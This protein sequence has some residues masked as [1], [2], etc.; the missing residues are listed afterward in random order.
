MKNDCNVSIGEQ[1]AAAIQVVGSASSLARQ[2]GVTPQA[3]CFWRDG[4]RRFP[5]ALGARI[6]AITSG[7]VTRKDMFPRDW[8][9][10]WP[11]LAD[12]EE[13][14]APAP[15]QQAQAA[16]NHDVQGVVHG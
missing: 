11:E 16:I 1:I 12:S 3:V 14:Q 7:R 5:E 6:E 10:I 4:K 9:S 13:K 2:L 15:T 8:A